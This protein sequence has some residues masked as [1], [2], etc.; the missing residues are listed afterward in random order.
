MHAYLHEYNVILWELDLGEL[1]YIEVKQS[2]VV[3]SNSTWE[4]M[5]HSS[6]IRIVS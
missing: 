2:M 6:V 1:L 5:I 3:G 4:D